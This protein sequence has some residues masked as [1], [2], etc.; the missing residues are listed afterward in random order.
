MVPWRE[1]TLVGV[2]H[3]VVPRDPDAAGLT[4]D[5]LRSFIAEINACHPG[6]NLRESEVERVDFGLVPFGDA[7]DQGSG[8]ISFG[9]QSR[10]IDHSQ[11]D[12]I[13]GLV[14]SISVRYT[15]ARMDAVNALDCAARQLLSHA[16]RDPRMAHLT[17]QSM[18][19]PG[20]AIE[21]FEALAKDVERNRPAWLSAVSAATLLAN[22]GTKMPRVLALAETDAALRSYVAGT[23]VTFAEIECALRDEMAQTM[24][25]IV[26]RRTELGTG[27][28][29]GEAALADVAA[30]MQAKLDWTPARTQEERRSVDAQFARY[31][32]SPERIR[33]GSMSGTYASPL[34]DTFPAARAAPLGQTA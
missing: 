11:S 22:F 20:G 3:S 31:L 34:L 14:T 19:L 18:P 30:F 28:H 6:F 29:P 32:A 16:S 5:E 2:W 26:F 1:R 7:A 21:D 24:S 10:L 23:D 8:T 17:S 25:D 27:G 9:K 33:E 13:A 4:R 15:V 12:G